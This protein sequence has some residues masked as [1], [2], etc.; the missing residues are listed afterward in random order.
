MSESIVVGTDG[1]ATANRAVAEA[2][3]WAAALGAELHLVSAH[4]PMRGAGLAGASLAGG[5]GFAM[6]PAEDGDARVES[7]LAEAA[8]SIRSADVRVTTHAVRGNPAD[9][10]VEVANAHGANL[11]VVGNKGMH[12]VKRVLGSVPNAVSHNARCNVLIVS[13][14][15]E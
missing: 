1:S 8:A 4:D 9:A 15:A 7:T 14:D 13:T 10:L 11:I 3:R 12:G 5:A 6:P 2:V